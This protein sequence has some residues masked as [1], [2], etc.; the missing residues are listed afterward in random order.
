MNKALQKI[1]TQSIIRQAPRAVSELRLGRAEDRYGDEVHRQGF[2]TQP[3]RHGSYVDAMHAAVKRSPPS[4]YQTVQD[5]NAAYYE[6]EDTME[7]RGPTNS[8][9]HFS[10]ESG[11]A[12]KV[13]E[14]TLTSGTV[15]F[16]SIGNGS[17]KRMSIQQIPKRKSKQNGKATSTTKLSLRRDVRA[18]ANQLY[19]DGYFEKG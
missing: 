6:S 3:P 7:M 17:L 10:Q 12:L 13:A 8:R 18:S 9:A 19:A 16:P 2:T 1:A 4:G 15:V 11:A 5:S 14:S